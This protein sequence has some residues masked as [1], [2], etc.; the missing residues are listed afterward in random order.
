MTIVQHRI[1][2]HASPE[3]VWSILNDL[4]AVR[5]YNSSVRS[6]TITSETRAGVGATRSCELAPKGTVVERVTLCEELRAIGFE[7]VKSDWPIHFMRWTTSLA[8]DSEG[9]VISQQLSYKVK[10]GPL[11]W[12]LDQLVM[13]RKLS[14]TLDNVFANLVRVCE[15]PSAANRSAL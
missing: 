9:T 3:R 5:S 6:V 10:F 8:A 4:E 15:D 14:A 13:K 7:V 11:G 1:R 12:L 2:T